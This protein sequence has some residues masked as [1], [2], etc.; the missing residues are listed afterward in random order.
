MG[1]SAKLEPFFQKIDSKIISEWRDTVTGNE[2]FRERL[3]NALIKDTIEY[4]KKLAE[5]FGS[6]R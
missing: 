5:K 1:N 3:E 4:R 6:K 2:T